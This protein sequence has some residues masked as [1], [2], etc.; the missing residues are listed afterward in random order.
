MS[1]FK[2]FSDE[3]LRAESQYLREALK[4]TKQTLKHQRRSLRLVRKEQRRRK[5]A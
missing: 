4:I 3:N 2:H 5:R 1:V